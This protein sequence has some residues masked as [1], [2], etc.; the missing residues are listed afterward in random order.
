LINLRHPCIAAPIGFVLQLNQAVGR[1]WK[2]FDCI[3]RAA[4]YPKSFLFIESGGH[5]Q[6]KRKQLQELCLL[7]DLRTVLDWCTA[8]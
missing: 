3:Q 8:S 7:F 4:H 2:L 5:R 1:N 6:W